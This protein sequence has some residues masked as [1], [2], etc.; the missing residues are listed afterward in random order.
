MAIGN[1]I[2]SGNGLVIGAC[3]NFTM[4]GAFTFTGTLTGNTAV[5]FPT[6][7]TLATSS[8]AS[9]PSIAQGDLLYG[10]NTNVLS[11]LSKDTNATR[12]LSNQ[13]TSNNP[14]W[15]QVNLANGV[16]GNLPVG[17]L[18]TGTSASSS[19]FWRGDGTWAVPAGT[20][21]TSVSGTANRITSTGG[22]TPV[23][24]ISASYVGQSS[25]TTVGALSSGSLAAGFTVVTG[26][27]GG[28]GIA[29]TGKTIT[30]G[31]SLTTSGAFDSTFTMTNTTAVTFPTSGT[32]ATTGG[33]NIPAVVQGDLLYGSNTNVL[34]ALNKD[35]NA[36]RYLSNTGTSNNPAWAQVN[37]ANGVT[38]TLPA[39]NG[40]T[41]VANT[42]TITLGGNIST[43]GAHTLSGAFASTFT[44]TNT[45]SVTFPT[46]GTLSTTTGTV[47]SV[48]T[49]GLATGGTITSTGTITVTAAS[50]TDQQN[51]TSTTTVV[52]P[53]VQQ[54]HPSAVKAYV[55]AG[56]TGNTIIG[57][58]ISSVTD[59]GTGQITFNFT[60]A[61][62]DGNIAFPG[63]VGGGSTAA[64]IFM[65]GG[66]A[67]GGTS[68]NGAC[69]DGLGNFADPAGTNT[70]HVVFM[71]T[72]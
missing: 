46:S 20:G 42:N 67:G 62:P 21:V 10:S 59:V 28:T 9:I 69:T 17:N 29:N 11:A 24:D 30:L 52:T 33:A 72:Q 36:T 34:S 4:A 56:I 50:K 68:C 38:G 41:G 65:D 54:Y 48:A 13:G 5:T 3:T 19:T 15:N 39:G 64:R 22:T 66:I 1:A 26:A 37:L 45:T 23:I 55:E 7:G 18:N 71:G 43:A 2:N 61:F 49:A 70:W 40:G 31:G 12:Y 58:N 25:I 47:T 60:V 27:L 14:S 51:L 16:T 6:S 32:L 35:T 53:S 8:G 63:S 44:F 57:Y